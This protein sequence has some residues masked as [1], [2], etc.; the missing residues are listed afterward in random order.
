LIIVALVTGT[1]V[2]SHAQDDENGG[3]WY[4]RG[5][6]GAAG[7]D[8]S[9]LETAIK[10]SKQALIDNGV[11]LSTYSYNFD[12][13]W[14]YRVELGA[15]LFK[16][17][18]LGLMFD[19]QPRSDDQSVSG[20]GAQD[21]LRMSEDIKITYYAIFGN[22]TYWFPGTH[23]FFVSGRA[24]YGSG[25]FQQTLELV[26]P[27]NPQIAVSGEGDYDGSNVVYG[28]SGGYQYKFLNGFLLYLELGY[29]Q[30]NL[31]TFTG[32]T[33]T[34]N[35]NMFPSYSGTYTVN[36]EEID[37][38]FTGPFVAVGFGFTGPY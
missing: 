4:I 23:S 1:V 9:A 30:R 20:V 11:D 7:Q 35:E 3:V 16:G 13:I 6:F 8:L 33:T 15:V 25:R 29:E 38:D 10:E 2:V 24:G 22:V 21:Q 36:G 31:G 37:F 12:T 32:T 19:Y 5:S 17:F 18:S 28:F 34:T 14:D 27:S 26:D